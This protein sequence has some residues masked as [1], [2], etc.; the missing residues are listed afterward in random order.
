MNKKGVIK[1]GIVSLLV[2][3]TVAA[4][5]I[6]SGVV[7]S[8]AVIDSSQ[9]VLGERVRIDLRGYGTTDLKIITPSTTYKYKA[10]NERL[11][12]R[13]KE[14]GIYNVEILS[15]GVREYYSFEVIGEEIPEVPE[16]DNETVLVPEEPFKSK[17]ENV[18]IV[19]DKPVKNSEELG[20]VK[21]TRTKLVIPKKDN[22]TVYVDTPSGTKP[23]DFEVSDEY[24]SEDE[25]SIIVNDVDGDVR[26]EYFTDPPRK[27]ERIV[28]VKK[29]EVVVSSPE[30]LDYQDVLAFTEIP[31]KTFRKD[32]IEVFWKE[33]NRSM[34]FE[35]YDRDGDGLFDF[36][37]WVVPHLSNQT[38]E[39]IV[40]TSAEH[41]DEN[42]SFVSDI[43]PWVKDKDNNWS[44]IIPDGHFVKVIFEKQLNNKK[45]ITI[46]ARNF[47]GNPRIE[48]Y[49]K[50]G[51]VMLA[52]FGLI[53]DD[54]KYRILLTDLVGFQDTFDLKVVGGSVEFDY[55]VDPVS[56]PPPN[57]GIFK[58]SEDEDGT[59]FNADSSFSGLVWASQNYD[60]GVLN[61]NVINPTRIEVLEDGDYFLALSLPIH[62]EDFASVNE[63]RSSI[64]AHVH[65]NGV[66]TGFSSRPSYLRL[67]GDGN[68][69]HFETSD[70][71]AVLIPNLSSGDYI[72]IKVK[73]NA[74][75]ENSQVVDDEFALFVEKVPEDDEIFAAYG[76]QADS[77]TDLNAGTEDVYSTDMQWNSIVKDSIFTH[78]DGI[79]NITLSDIGHYY[80][81]VN[82]PLSGSVQRASVGG[83]VELDGVEV[84]G[85][86]FHQGYIRNA[87][88]HTTASIHW[89]GLVETSSANQNLSIG[90]GRFAN[91]NTITTGGQ[92]ASLFVRKLSNGNE[93]IFHSTTIVHTGGANWNPAS[94]GYILWQTP[95]E[96][97]TSYYTHTDNTENITVNED[98]Y[99]LLSFNSPELLSGGGARQSPQF[100]VYVDGVL[101]NAS[102]TGSTYN[103]NN[104]GHTQTSTSLVYLLNLDA[105]QSIKI[106]VRRGDGNGDDATG[107]LSANNEGVIFIEH[108]GKQ[109]VEWSE[110]VLDF[111]ART[112]SNGNV[113]LGV[114]ITAKGDHENVNVT[115][116]SGNCSIL[117]TNWTNGVDM[118]SGEILEVYFTCS[119][120]IEGEFE[121]YYNVS[122]D[123][124]TSANQLFVTCVMSSSNTVLWNQSTLRFRPG[125]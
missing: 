84:T 55:I 51:S 100:L 92:N 4:F 69:D 50:N 122:S 49:E 124:S 71:L 68:P 83:R 33:E 62:D 57:G 118:V 22:F 72:E 44:E 36:I 79:S 16:E 95:N 108:K 7:F 46:Y 45:D 90:V 6:L 82:I 58:G 76:T 98:G 103:R 109:V 41:L 110:S 125:L 105:G 3:G 10:L 35:A 43:Y 18:S 111:G 63:K 5:L 20:N 64:E 77:G 65:V 99:Y 85:G 38:F 59:D 19:V 32:L 39:I 117:T 75:T 53:S 80:V 31:E 56:E 27:E 88:G 15:N 24:V 112:Q 113:T 48:V 2:I 12:F 81:T 86:T 101:Q 23:V 74:N 70:N 40:I 37:E 9:Y 1:A 61:Y 104:N 107:S 91:S 17:Y 96:K 67:S 119:N 54:K 89:A 8:S 21:A 14:V 78:T 34:D 115:C 93:G 116:D 87:Q 26:L 102:R 11:L 52:D 94:E 97:D 73:G 60:D 29:K 123:N 28:S 30:G 13:P 66:A 114:N 25:I 42:R 47:S 106:G 121:A 120:A